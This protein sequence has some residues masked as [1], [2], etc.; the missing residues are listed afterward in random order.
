MKINVEKNAEKKQIQMRKVKAE[1][2][3]AKC[4]IV[5]RSLKFFHTYIC[6]CGKPENR[7]THVYLEKFI[8]EI[9]MLIQSPNMGEV[10]FNT[11]TLRSH[12][13]RFTFLG[14]KKIYSHYIILPIFH[15]FWHLYRFPIGYSI[16]YI[17]TSYYIYAIKKNRSLINLISFI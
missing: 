4:T 6:N 2:F 5:F 13:Y 14:K 9:P 17:Y 10:H 15:K 1:C 3:H 12:S 8:R 7:K 11:C 16:M